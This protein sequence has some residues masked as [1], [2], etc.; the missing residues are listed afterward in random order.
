[1]KTKLSIIT[2]VLTITFT[3]H[4]QIEQEINSFV[5]STEILVNNGRKMILKNLTDNNIG[6]AEEA[7]QYLEEV[8]SKENFFAFY[9][10]EDLYINILAGNWETTRHLMQNYS[11]ITESDK[12]VYPSSVQ[13]IPTLNKLVKER[14]GTLTMELKNPDLDAESQRTLQ[15]LFYVIE[16]DQID[17]EYN[18]LLTQYEE[19]FPDSKYRDFIK[20][21]L[22][23]KVIK[24]SWTFSIGSGIVMPTGNL[25]DN[26]NGN[27]SINMSMDV[28]I[29][30]VFAS[31]H[32]NTATLKL[33]EPFQA[34]SDFETLDFE[35]DEGF[36]YLDA[37][38]KGGYFL[39]RSNRFHVAPYLAISGSF[40]E[41][42]RFDTDEDDREFEV[43]NS[44]TYGGGIHTEL[45]IHDFQITDIYGGETTHFLSLK[46]DA[47][48]N[49][50]AKI[51]DSFFQGDIP[52]VT[53]ALNWGF[54]D[55]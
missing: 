55:F 31:M 23:S 19:A 38:L 24:A 42:R 33:Q 48:Y 22:P 35:Y 1:M 54:G 14:V 8:V 52:Y 49:R 36:H 17:K 39:V 28:N 40:L 29:N 46:L 50:M 7:Y 18:T 37:G 20:H 32:L 27:A 12:P 11:E 41:S 13:M 10:I 30:K 9:Y 15:L 5:D 3:T 47:G 43:F 21:F 26:F 6:K 44:F 53:M 2:L 16:T 4:A 51:E 45:K 25:A 34:I